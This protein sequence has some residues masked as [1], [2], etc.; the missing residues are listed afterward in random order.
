MPTHAETI[1]AL[2]IDNCEQKQTLLVTL[3][4]AQCSGRGRQSKHMDTG[5]ITIMI[6]AVKGKYLGK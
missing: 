2:E 5:G 4:H 3:W 6:R 1:P